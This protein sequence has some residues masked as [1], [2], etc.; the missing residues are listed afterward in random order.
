LNFVKAL[1]YVPVNIQT[2]HIHLNNKENTV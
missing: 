1:S 2:N